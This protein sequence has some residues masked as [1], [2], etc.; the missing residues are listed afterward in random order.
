MFFN[1]TK[2]TK[3]LEYEE[4]YEDSYD[5]D[6]YD[7]D[8][9]DEDTY[10]EY[11]SEEDYE[12]YEEDY[13]E[14]D[15]DW[16]DDDIE[17]LE[18]EYAQE[19]EYDDLGAETA[20]QE[21]YYDEGEH[22]EE[23]EYYDEGEYSEEE[24]YYDEEEYSEEQV[25]YAEETEYP[26]EQ[27]YYA[28]N[29]VEFAEEDSLEEEF[30]PEPDEFE[31]VDLEPVEYEEEKGFHPGA[32]DVMLVVMGILAVVLILAFGILYVKRSGQS[33]EAVVDTKLVYS[34]GDEL[35]GME[36]AGEQGL[37]ALSAYLKEQ[38]EISKEPESEEEQPSY[39]EN[40]F[41]KT[42]AVNMTTTSVQRDLK[43]KFINRESKKLIS[44]VP[45]CVTVTKPDKTTEE[46]SDNDYDGIIHKKGL[47]AGE[48]KIQIM[49]LDPQKYQGFIL[50]GNDQKVEV[51]DKIS[52]AKV[53][54]KDEVKTENEVNVSKEDTKVNETVVESEIK[55]TVEWVAS[56]A[57]GTVY[58]EV[59]KTQ[60]L[61]PMEVSAVVSATSRKD[62]LGETVFHYS[63]ELNPG[64]DESS[65]ESEPGSATE[66]SS[67]PESSS[68]AESSS[69]PE[70]SSTAESSSTVESSSEPESSSTVESSSEPESSTVESSSTSE[71]GSQESTEPPQPEVPKANPSIKAEAMTYIAFTGEPVLIKTILT[72][73]LVE[74]PTL[75]S[76]VL[77][78]P[79]AGTVE[80]EGL[81]FT[82]TA[83][84]AEQK[85][86]TAKAVYKED[87]KTVE[88]PCAIVIRPHPKTD[89]TTKL[90]TKEAQQVFVLEGE[91]YR[92]AVYADYFTSEHFYI[93]DG[94][95]YT[96][97][98]TVDG[99]QYFYNASGERVTGTQVIQGA[100]YQFGE[101]GALIVD[102]GV[103]G[104]DVSK[105]NGKI[106]WVAVK[107]SGV[108]Y[109]IIRCGYRGST[110]GAIIEDPTFTANIQ[111]AISA[112]LKVGVYFFTQAIDEVEAVYEASYVLDKIK[113]Y[114]ITYPV[115]LD[116]EPSKGRGDKI[117][118]A[119]R[120][121]VCKA[122]CETIKGAG[123]TPGI[124]AN[125]TWLTTK[126]DANALSDYKIWL[127][128]YAETP[129]YAG[130]YDLWQYK[131]NGKIDGI[132]GDVDLNISY[133]G[134]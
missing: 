35:K 29:D 125:K 101:D 110:A 43:L 22:S 47:E 11:D 127:A 27:V 5:E 13:M 72:G 96:G 25:Y 71:S 28:E 107:N 88:A 133:L 111:G 16:E 87:D 53:E 77:S 54:V 60:L 74:K 134:Y 113:N 79:A 37:D 89:T 86:I 8:S 59:L 55:N 122:F 24:E 80:I 67:E 9:Y 118:T 92:E 1:K 117:D 19:Q 94:A 40:E 131:E 108:S 98:Q 69:E 97:W 132:E 4:F 38:Q 42:I 104:I 58:T 100:T 70:S 109:A 52:Y 123:Y 78:D 48:Y 2:R 63:T 10:D 129:T 95:K 32:L 126:L 7:E 39:E 85:T 12:E 68:T 18:E 50:P 121:A 36:M 130:K 56:T 30:Y 112:G 65:S 103:M 73:N 99:K 64:T 3:D 34:V 83:A 102:S 17:N 66:S 116:V 62:H 6:T 76:V 49:A 14:D 124:Y 91:T 33:E 45:F 115:F 82:F 106:D 41:T 114:R 20:E 31:Q 81:N 57:T 84:I 46:W 93:S 44:N 23:E 120:T 119:T 128:Q 90:L 51:K 21:E 61:N 26:E 15:S 105:W 75:D